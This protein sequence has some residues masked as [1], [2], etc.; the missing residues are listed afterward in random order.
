MEIWKHL[1]ANE[2]THERG[3][4]LKASGDFPVCTHRW[5]GLLDALPFSSSFF[6]GGGFSNQG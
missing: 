4:K 6:W 2:F 1:E 3:E 5:L